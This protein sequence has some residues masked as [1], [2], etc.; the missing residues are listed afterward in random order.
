ME[1]YE[2]TLCT[3]KEVHVFKIPP[4][5]SSEGYKAEGWTQNHLWSG[6]CRVVAIGDR[7]EV[8]LEDSQT[9]KNFATCNVNGKGAVEP[10]TDSSRYF[11]LRI[12]DLK[13]GRHAF[14][15]IGFA[16]RSD[17]FDFNVALQ[18]HE[19]HINRMKQPPP[20]FDNEPKTDY[21]MKDGEKIKVNFKVKTK[22]KLNTA[23]SSERAPAE[24]TS[25]SF[26]PPPSSNRSRR[27]REATSTSNSGSGN[28]PLNFD[29]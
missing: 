10:V 1:D 11:V 20:D 15:G 22:G 5:Q 2:Q 17:A 18:D 3:I 4:L 26:A 12:E 9:G 28:N 29:F 23:S 25:L 14:I 21:S 19:K 8:R 7:C 6:R 27:T 24:T 13:T 16:E